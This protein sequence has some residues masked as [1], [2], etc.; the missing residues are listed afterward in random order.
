MGIGYGR[1]AR[2]IDFMAEDGYVGPYNGS[3]AREVMLT[4]EQWDNIQAGDPN[5]VNDEDWPDEQEATA[6]EVAAE[7]KV[8]FQTE[9]TGTD[10]TWPIRP[11]FGQRL[12]GQENARPTKQE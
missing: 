12:V 3:K 1:A 8:T 5:P 9:K 2:L 4:E 7:D 10:R 11:P 6:D